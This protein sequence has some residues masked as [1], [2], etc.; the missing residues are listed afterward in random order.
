MQAIESNI[1]PRNSQLSEQEESPPDTKSISLKRVFTKPEQ[2]P[3]I[4]ADWEFRSAKITDEKGNVVFQQ[5]GIQAPTSWSQLATNI[6]VSKYFRGHPG[7]STRETSVAQVITRVV[8]VITESG[9]KQDYFN[10]PGDA[11]TFRDE[12]A[13]III[14]QLGTFNSPVWFNVGIVDKPQCSACFINSVE[15]NMNSILGLARTEAMLFK[16]GSGTG[17]NFS[18]IRSSKERLSGGG[19][20]SGPI[21]FMK[22]YDAFTGAVKSGGKT[23]RAA[24][25][26]ML[27][28]DHP[29]ILEF[30]QCKAKEERKAW[31]LIDAGYDGSIDGEAYSTVSFQN[32][33]NCIRVTDEFMNAV[34]ENGQ[35]ETRARTTGE[36]M[37]T[38]SAKDL[39]MEMAKAAHQCGDPGIQFDTTINKYNTCE[40]SGRINCSN[41]CAEFHFLD[42]SACNLASINLLPFLNEDGTFDIE[43]FKHTVDVFITAQDIIVDMASY[44]TPEIWTNSHKLRAL[45]IGYSNLG[46]TLMAMGMPYDSDEGRNAAAAITA[47]MTGESYAQSARIAALKGPFE[48]FDRNRKSMYRVID[49]HRTALSDIDTIADDEPDIYFAAERAWDNAKSLGEQ[50]GYRNAQVSLLAPTGTISFMMDCDTT[51]VEPDFALVKTKNLVG[52]GVIKIHNKAVPLA[53]KRLGYSVEEIQEITDFVSENGTVE[54]MPLLHREHLPVFDCAMKP[55]NGSRY[56]DPMGHLKMVAALQ[57][58]LSG[59]ISKTIN[60]PNHATSEEIFDLYLK[61]W[62]LGV[63]AIIVYREG[64]KRIQPIQNK[65]SKPIETQK[66]E[67]APVATGARRK[68]LPNERTSITHKFGIA[69]HEGY[70]TVGQ[71]DDGTPGELFIRMSKA[72]SAINGLMDSLALAVSLA[73]QYGV[74]LEVLVEKF[75]HTRFEP[76]G[77]TSNQ[78]IPTATSL[79]DYVFRWLASKYLSDQPIPTPAETVQAQR[80]TDLE[81]LGKTNSSIDGPVCPGCGQIMTT[82]TGT[83]YTCSTCGTSGGCG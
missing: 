38:H 20:A 45:G 7:S 76:A 66:P 35:W 15:D 24:K 81:H 44:P 46:A 57:P 56:I 17:T 12:L 4:V 14:N 37:S 25:I 36:V 27:D 53:L 16:G 83:C 74:P 55:E 65:E 28:I 18:T 3:F 78:N 10:N 42:D 77:F 72:G 22:G 2:S 75:S 64:S 19:M 48:E 41:P 68:R 58:F 54:G 71:Y 49:L 70:L 61:A 5:D 29:D 30:I 62:Q 51:G 67:T 50:F 79:T 21:A 32:S 60:L 34:I 1:A 80:M 6:V 11:E 33:N 69:G 31:T 47:L 9:I 43:S 82:R 23:R 59:A 40:E 63:K 39:L 13:F 8:D 26:V 73:L 52:G